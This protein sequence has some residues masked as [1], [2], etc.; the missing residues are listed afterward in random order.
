MEHKSHSIFDEEKGIVF[1]CLQ[2][3]EDLLTGLIAICEKHGIT[4][5]MVSCIGS[6]KEVCF[7]HGA[8]DKNGAPTY[9]AEKKVQGAI[10]LLSGTGVIARNEEGELDI[11][12]HGLIVTETGEVLG[13]HFLKGKN[14]ILV[15]LEF[16]IITSGKLLATRAFNPSLGFRL[17]NFQEKG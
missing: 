3:G 6:L 9:S 5:G 4:A 8:S 10:E 13:G 11:H 14:E 16:T 7:I 1:G 2:K 12:F 15:T 17:T